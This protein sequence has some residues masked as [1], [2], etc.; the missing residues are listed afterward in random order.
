MKDYEE[1]DI[2]DIFSRLQHSKPLVIG[3]KVKAL[4]SDFKPPIRELVDHKIFKLAPAYRNRDAHWNLASLFFKAVYKKNPYDRQEY[5][6]LED[7]LRHEP[8]DEAAAMKAV[9]QTK[10]LQ[11]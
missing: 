2:L 9:A 10:Q 1:D 5:Q 3:E 11:F 7:F 4:R 8:Y 6:R